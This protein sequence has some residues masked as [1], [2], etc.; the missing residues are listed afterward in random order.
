MKIIFKTLKFYNF[1]NFWFFIV[2]NLYMNKN[3]KNVY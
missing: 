2:K 3:E 1:I